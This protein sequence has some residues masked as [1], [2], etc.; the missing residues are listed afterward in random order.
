FDLAADVPSEVTGS[1]AEANAE[2]ALSD[3]S[4]SAVYFWYRHH[5]VSLDPDSGRN[6]AFE[7]A[8]VRMN[9]PPP[10]AR[11]GTLI[12]MDPQGRLVLY[13]TAPHAKTASSMRATQKPDWSELIRSAALDTESLT[14]T[15]P[16]QTVPY[17][18]SRM[19]WTGRHHP[20]SDRV[21]I[22]AA[23]LGGAPV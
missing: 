7:Y 10:L 2:M 12:V 5:P 18:D 8:R 23:S 16:R 19:A 14:S 9:D 17:A 11:G 20:Q 6:L 1:S 13:Q 21:R 4:H 22:E 3:Q 15:Q